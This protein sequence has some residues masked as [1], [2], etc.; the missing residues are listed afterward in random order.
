[1]KAFFILPFILSIQILTAQTAPEIEWQNTIVGNW[2][3]LFLQFSCSV[4]LPIVIIFPYFHILAPKL[5]N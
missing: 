5:K 3:D 1:M 2:I 4:I